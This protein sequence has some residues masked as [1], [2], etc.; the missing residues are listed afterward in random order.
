VCVW[1]ASKNSLHV[2]T[3]EEGVTHEKALTY[4][5]C[6]CAL[7]S[8]YILSAESQFESLVNLFVL[9]K[10]DWPSIFQR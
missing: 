6:T 2:T 9:M 7:I 5:F 10:V 8:E 4:F 1:G 3:H